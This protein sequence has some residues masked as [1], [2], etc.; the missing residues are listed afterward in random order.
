MSPSLT[1]ALRGLARGSGL[2]ALML[3]VSCASPPEAGLAPGPYPGSATTAAPAEQ[4][5][6]LARQ[7]HVC[8]A[9]VAV[10]R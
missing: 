7:H 10:I 5:A 9:A 3:V 4:L 2:A 8:A 1:S 6:Q